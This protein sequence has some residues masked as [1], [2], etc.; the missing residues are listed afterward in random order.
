[1]NRVP[2]DHREEHQ[3]AD[4]DA[5]TSN[6][7]GRLPPARPSPKSAGMMH[8]H[9][10]GQHVFDDQPA[11]G[12]VAGRSVQVPAVGED[13][14]E[15]DRAGHR[16]R[17]AEDQ[18]GAPHPAEPMGDQ[19]APSAVATP[20]W[21][22]APG[23]ATRRTASSSSTWNCKPTPNI[24]RITPISASCSAR[25]WSATKPG[26]CGPTRTPAKR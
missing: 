13:A 25:C 1:M 26:V 23:I 24:S 9:E 6:A 16:Q 5:A 8:E 17:E 14:D 3:R 22:S 21:T 12:N 7:R 18:P 2:A 10:H 19:S 11:D 20:L 4:L 15:H